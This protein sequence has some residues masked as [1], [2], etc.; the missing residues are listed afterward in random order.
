MYSSP[1]LDFVLPYLAEDLGEAAYGNLCS[2]LSQYIRYGIE[3]GTHASK[4]FKKL[5]KEISFLGRLNEVHKRFE[6][7]IQTVM[8][9]PYFK[10]SITIWQTYYCGM[11]LF[12]L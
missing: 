6:P 12:Y 11:V 2:V 5:I 7:Y 10:Y 8:D 4:Q 1:Y 3:T 9:S